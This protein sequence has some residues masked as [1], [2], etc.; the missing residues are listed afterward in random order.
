MILRTQ[1]TANVTKA[2]GMFLQVLPTSSQSTATADTDFEHLCKLTETI[3]NEEIFELPAEDILHRLY[4]QE[5]IEVYPAT[6]VVFKCSCSKE[7]SAAALTGVSKEELLA[8]AAKDGDIKM[9]CQYC[10]TQYSFDTIDIESIHAGTF[11]MPAG[12]G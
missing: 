11:N 7:R 5:Q 2:C 1:V 3:K 6:N 10:H 12:Q 4:H 8:I 9:N